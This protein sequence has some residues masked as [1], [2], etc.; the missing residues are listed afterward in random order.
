MFDIKTSI[1]SPAIS[2][3]IFIWGIFLINIFIS[4]G[5]SSKFRAF[6]KPIIVLSNAFEG[7]SFKRISF[8]LSQ[9]LSCDLSFF[10]CNAKKLKLFF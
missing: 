2:G 9:V 10:G 4:C 1:R 7:N 8:G 5:S 6:I 3:V